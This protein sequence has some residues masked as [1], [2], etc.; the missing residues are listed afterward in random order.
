MVQFDEIRAEMEAV[1]T[2]AE[3]HVRDAAAFDQPAPDFSGVSALKVHL[4]PS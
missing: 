1:A 4:P 2:E 3:Q